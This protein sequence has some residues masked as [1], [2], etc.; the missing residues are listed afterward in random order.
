MVRNAEVEMT[1]APNMVT[2][3]VASI[4]SVRWA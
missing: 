1:P 2:P 3:T 4:P